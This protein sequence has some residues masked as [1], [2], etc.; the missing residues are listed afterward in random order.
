MRLTERQ[1]E[2][3]LLVCRGLTNKEI[4]KAL[5]ISHGTVKHHVAQLLIKLNVPRRSALALA[6]SEHRHRY[7]SM[8]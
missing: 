4:A 8:R 1:S 5:D 7:G 2:V 6:L 3:G